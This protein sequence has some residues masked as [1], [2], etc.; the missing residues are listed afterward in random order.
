MGCW[1][2]GIFDDD[3]ALDIRDLYDDVI[4]KG[5]S[6][7]IASA[8]VMKL[9]NEPANNEDDGIIVYSALS[10][11]QLSRSNLFQNIREKTIALIDSNSG[12]GRWEKA[13]K[14][15]YQKKRAELNK[16]KSIL[17][18]AQTIQNKDSDISIP[19][20]Y[21]APLVFTVYELFKGSKTIYIGSTAFPEKRFRYMN[22]IEF[23]KGGILRGLFKSNNI[24]KEQEFWEWFSINEEEL[25]KSTSV[26]DPIVNELS[27]R[28]KKINEG[29]TFEFSRI[30]DDKRT[31]AISANGLREVFPYVLKLINE[32]KL[33]SKWIVVPFR[34]RVNHIDGMEIKCGD[35]SLGGNDIS[36]V[37]KQKESRVSLDIYVRGIN[38]IP[39]EIVNAVFLM[40][41]SSIGEYD[42]VTKI[43]GIEILPESKL[44]DTVN[45]KPLNMLA[46]LV[47]SM[48]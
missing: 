40:L 23:E 22:F 33:L 14:S 5:Y 17:L 13:G 44:K 15:E 47:D 28:L 26:E 45:A 27:T 48:K 2:V 37:P 35:F 38:D 30:I 31:I 10:C 29:L 34:Q 9:Y 46:E 8:M 21:T 6:D 25:F 39:P 36:F 32:P 16:L 3:L 43:G 19:E 18:K 24:N 20:E 41:D 11:I 4:K 7:S 42:V 1:G 12:L